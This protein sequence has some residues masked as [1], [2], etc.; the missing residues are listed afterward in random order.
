MARTMPQT[1]GRTA[2]PRRGRLQAYDHS[3]DPVFLGELTWENVRRSEYSREVIRLRWLD[4]PALNDQMRKYSEM[5]DKVYEEL[6]KSVVLCEGDDGPSQ[7]NAL[8]ALIQKTI[9]DQ[10]LSAPMPE[11]DDRTQRQLDACLG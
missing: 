5:P 3:A 4:Q 1:V 2:K 9:L 7:R 8:L 6:C 11:L 10:V